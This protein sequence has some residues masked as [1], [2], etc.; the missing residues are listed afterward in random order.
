MGDEKTAD[1]RPEGNEQGERRDFDTPWKKIVKAYFKEFVHFFFPEI[2]REID[3]SK[4]YEF[5]DKEL[6]KIAKDAALGGRHADVMACVHLL[7]GVEEWVLCHIEIQGQN[8]VG[9]PKRMYVYNYRGFDSFDRKVASLAVLAD[10]NP[11]WR[12]GHYSYEVL[13]TKAGLW[14]PT[15]KILDFKEKWD[16]LEDS[17]N[18]FAPVVMAHLKATE[19]G[20]DAGSRYRWKLYL[21]RRLYR[22]GYGRREV[23]LLFEFIDWIMTLPEELE[24][25]LLA[26]IHKIEREKKM[27][28]ITS[29]Q[30]IGR[31]EGRQEGVTNLLERLVSKKFNID[32][33]TLA[34]VFA[35]FTTEQIEELADF[36]VEARTLEEIRERA[37]EM[38]RGRSSRLSSGIDIG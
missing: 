7:S 6:L 30:R 1:E 21:V 29:V 26:E 27:E 12:P 36:F 2:A 4:G 18:P 31:Q 24:R 19:T 16:W 10:D 9:F 38:R 32:R 3:W 35:G 22:M 11:S 17:P 14:F 23:V 15:V 28:Y 13:G 20:N 25:G 34:P 5:L 33:Q 8:Q 37:D